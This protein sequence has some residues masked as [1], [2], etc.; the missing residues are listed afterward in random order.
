[1]IEL[2]AMKIKILAGFVFA[3]VFLY[4]AFLDAGY[5]HGTIIFFSAAMPYGTGLL[6][7]PF[8]F[9]LT[10]Y[11]DSAAVR[12]IYLLTAIIHYFV[13][14]VFIFLWWNEDFPYLL[15][16]WSLSPAMV[17]L[18]LVWYGLGQVF[19][20]FSFFRNLDSKELK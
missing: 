9:A 12:L 4:L 6:I 2:Q 7:Y 18:P 15:K 8:L 19:I 17:L 11:L 10:E 20:W 16:V 14:A 3:G 13:T 1:L 5:G